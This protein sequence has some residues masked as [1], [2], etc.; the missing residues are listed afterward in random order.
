[1]A[2]QDKQATRLGC[3][4]CSIR[5][6]QAPY[7]DEAASK[8]DQGGCETYAS[9]AGDRRRIDLRE[10]LHGAI[11]RHLNDRCTR[12]L[13]VG[14]IVE[15]THQE[16][17][18]HET[19]NRSWNTRDSVRIHISVSWDCRSKGRDHVAIRSFRITDSATGDNQNQE[20]PNGSDLSPNPGNAIHT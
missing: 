12:A 8:R 20:G 1:M 4:R 13:Q 15:I 7:H 14:C 19:A 5:S 2:V 17:A 9:G 3:C 6:G 11:W 16:P 10:L 18:F